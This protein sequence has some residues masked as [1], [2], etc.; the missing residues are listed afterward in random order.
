[1]FA[2]MVIDLLAT[3][4]TPL[5]AVMVIWFAPWARAMPGADQV[6]VPWQVPEPPRSSTHSTS[7][8]PL[9]SL[10]VPPTVT[11]LPVT[12]A[13]PD[14]LGVVMATTGGAGAVLLLV[15]RTLSE[16]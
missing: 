16:T 13:E 2:V 4:F 12:V 8:M 6:V 10:A 9:A 5:R 3:R 7:T 1:M 11:V 15:T 14:E